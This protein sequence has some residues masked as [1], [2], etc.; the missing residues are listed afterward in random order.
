METATVV[1]SVSTLELFLAVTP[2]ALTVAPELIPGL[3][4]SSTPTT[5]A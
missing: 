1:E 4:P 2:N 3:N 5:P